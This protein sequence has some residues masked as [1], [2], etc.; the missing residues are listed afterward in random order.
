[1]DACHL[2][3]GRPWEFDR[4]VIHD[5]YLST[6]MFRFNDRTFNLKPTI[7]AI[8][9]TLTPSTQAPVLLMQRSPFENTLREE[10]IVF[11]L[12]T[13]PMKNARFNNVPPAFAELINEFADV[14]PE[15]LP[16]GLPPL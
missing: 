12:I 6:Y 1:M 7:K 2:L 14:F 4:R 8:H 11:I 9:E 3:L 10:G 16:T 13:K 5:G 15:D